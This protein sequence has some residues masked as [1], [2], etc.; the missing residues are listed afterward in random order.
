[1]DSWTVS[2]EWLFDW[3]W[4]AIMTWPLLLLLLFDHMTMLSEVSFGLVSFFI[5]HS[6]LY[7]F[8]YQC[9]LNLSDREHFYYRRGFYAVR[10]GIGLNLMWPFRM[11]TSSPLFFLFYPSHVK[12]VSQDCLLRQ[13]P[14]LPRLKFLHCI[15]KSIEPCHLTTTW[16]SQWCLLVGDAYVLSNQS[17]L[18]VSVRDP[19][20]SCC[21]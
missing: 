15:S 21:A 3:W 19:V 9:A 2:R 4:T 1:M 17:L 13:L 6:G 14:Q 5:S 8:A 18:N 12:G 16:F 11:Y 20:I 10:K 7:Y